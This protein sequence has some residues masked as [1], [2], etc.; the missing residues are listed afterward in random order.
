[1][2]ALA[3]ILGIIVGNSIYDLVNNML[4]ADSDVCYWI[5]VVLSVIL[6]IFLVA[7]LEEILLIIATSLMGAYMIVRGISLYGT[8]YPDEGYIYQLYHH[9]E[10]SSINRVVTANMMPYLIGF[11]VLFVIGLVVQFSNRGEKEDNKGEEED[12]G[13]IYKDKSKGGEDDDQGK[14]NNEQGN[15]KQPVNQN[16]ENNPPA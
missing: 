3:V 1:M 2:F 6:F 8:Q 11:L 10:L 14:T 16:P 13:K 7:K 12:D 9:K 15:D 5:I 4:T